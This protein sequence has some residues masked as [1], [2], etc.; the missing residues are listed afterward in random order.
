MWSLIPA[1]CWA[2]HLVGTISQGAIIL[3]GLQAQGWVAQR[4]DSKEQSLLCIC[5]LNSC[6][7]QW[8]SNM[9]PWLFPTAA[10]KQL[11]HLPCLVPAL[12]LHPKE[13][14]GHGDTQLCPSGLRD[15]F[16]MALADCPQRCYLQSLRVP[17]QRCSSCLQQYILTATGVIS[18]QPG[19]AAARTWG[20]R[21]WMGFSQTRPA[22]D[23]GYKT[24]VPAHHPLMPLPQVSYSSSA[25]AWGMPSLHP[26]WILMGDGHCLRSTRKRPSQSRPCMDMEHALK[27]SPLLFLCLAWRIEGTVTKAPPAHA[28]TSNSHAG[29]SSQLSDVFAFAVNTE[30]LVLPQARIP[31]LPLAFAFSSFIPVPFFLGSNQAFR[32]RQESNWKTIW[33][34]ESSGQITSVCQPKGRQSSKPAE[35]WRSDSPLC[36]D[37]PPSRGFSFQISWPFPFIR[38]I[39]KERKELGWGEG[40]QS[41]MYLKCCYY[42]HQFPLN[43]KN[44]LLPLYLAFIPLMSTV[45]CKTLFMTLM[46]SPSCGYKDALHTQSRIKRAM[47]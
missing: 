29:G 27:I 44:C 11:L 45:F 46:D 38:T 40:K 39:L 8:G 26:R 28:H 15:S 3:P 43:T 19:L 34:G 23:F 1:D 13:A 41:F 5:Q 35:P 9:H 18:S 2:Q 21:I 16:G 10:G 6:P 42:T 47:A 22:E 37:L 36:S 25:R 12:Y 20:Y 17:W 33:E 30:I 32:L 7:H 4:I 31:L 24:L 14:E